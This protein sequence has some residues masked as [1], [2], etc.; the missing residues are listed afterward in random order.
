MAGAATLLATPALA[1]S[2]WPQR[3]V[4]FI[5]PYTPGSAVDVAIR[6]VAADLSERLGQQFIVDNRLGGNGSVGT[7]AA[8]K[9]PP[10]GANFLVG[11]PGNMAINPAVTK[12]LRYDALRDF[13]AV[14]HLV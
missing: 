1:Q 9:S 10:D 14:N 11:S 5:F 6:I 3:V 7:E 2:A 13:I 12:G 4:R 8:A